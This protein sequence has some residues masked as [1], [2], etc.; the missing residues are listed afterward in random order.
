[1]ELALEGETFVT[2]RTSHQPA[3]RASAQPSC[4]VAIG[5]IGV[6]RAETPCFVILKIGALETACWML[7]GLQRLALL[8]KILILAVLLSSFSRGIT[9]VIILTLLYSPSSPSHWHPL[10][11][12]SRISPLRSPPILLYARNDCIASR[13]L[14]IQI[15]VC[16]SGRHPSSHVSDLMELD[17][18]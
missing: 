14:F 18:E 12:G 9:L 11:S 3:P 7:G 6:Y 13:T 4:R 2:P 15:T 5:I 1:M 17:F 8:S 16:F 10:S